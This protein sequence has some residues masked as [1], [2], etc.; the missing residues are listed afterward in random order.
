MVAAWADF[1][2]NC[3]WPKDYFLKCCFCDFLYEYLKAISKEKTGV[4]AV[5]I[6]INMKWK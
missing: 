6:S 1:L 2:L 5:N 3:I 4:I